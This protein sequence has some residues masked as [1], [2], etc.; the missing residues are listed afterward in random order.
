MLN[1]SGIAQEPVLEFITR[2]RK[3]VV[4]IIEN[5]LIKYC[6]D[7]AIYLGRVE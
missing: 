4:D 5:L 3:E 7:Y 2:D 1:M 6:N